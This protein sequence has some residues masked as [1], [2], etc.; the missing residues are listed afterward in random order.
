MKAHIL[1]LGTFLGMIIVLV[2]CKNEKQQLVEN[3]I[4]KIEHFVDSLK[5]LDVEEMA[6]NWEA[7]D[8]TFQNQSE[9]IDSLTDELPDEKKEV[10]KYRLNTVT[11]KYFDIRTVVVK[12]TV[13]IENPVLASSLDYQ[14]LRDQLFGA[15]VLG[16][17]MNFNWVNKSNI[18]SVYQKFYDSFKIN[19]D[20][21]TRE[22]FD[23]IKLMYE[24]LDTRKNTVEKE[25]LSSEDNSKIAAIKFRFAPMFKLN[26]IVAKSEENQEA[27]E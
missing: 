2:S 21:Y 16:K 9:E 12:D 5:T 14:K 18:L 6:Q 3:R 17:D 25:G 22:D 15:G 1:N 10:Y 7:I 23:E 13:E 27:K 20:K 26:R 4:D 24:A 11:T 8:G 19:K